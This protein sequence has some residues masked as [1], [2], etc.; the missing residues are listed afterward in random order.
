MNADSINQNFIIY[1]LRRV[2]GKLINTFDGIIESKMYCTCVIVLILDCTGHAVPKEC[3]HTDTFSLTQPGTH[4]GRPRMQSTR[5]SPASMLT[6]SVIPCFLKS[7]H[8]LWLKKMLA[9]LVR[10]PPGTLSK[11]FAWASGPGQ[12]CLWVQQSMLGPVPALACEEMP[13]IASVLVAALA[14]TPTGFWAGWRSR[15]AD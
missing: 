3:I 15:G 10:E 12:A 2:K 1:N 9:G 13:A 4:T 14:P 5:Q 8:T 6:T 11:V 7:A